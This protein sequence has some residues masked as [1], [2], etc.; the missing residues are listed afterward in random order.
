M[1]KAVPCRLTLDRSQ[2]PSR[3][4]PPPLDSPPLISLLHAKGRRGA[5]RTVGCKI[6]A[7]LGKLE[8]RRPEAVAVSMKAVLGAYLGVHVLAAFP[9]T[10]PVW[11]G[12]SQ[13]GNAPSLAV[14]RGRPRPRGPAS[15]HRTWTPWWGMRASTCRHCSSRLLSVTDSGVPHHWHLYLRFCPWW[16]L[17]SFHGMWCFG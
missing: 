5:W 14:D 1:V 7:A 15:W 10:S 17:I 8:G 2:L 3:P 11:L 16:P 9:M 13:G 12:S 4:V 6:E